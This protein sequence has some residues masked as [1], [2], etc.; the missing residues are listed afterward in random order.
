MALSLFLF[1]CVERKVAFM[2]IK[3]LSSIGVVVLD[4]FSIDY[5]Y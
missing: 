4:V 3:V 5:L 2:R 1:Y